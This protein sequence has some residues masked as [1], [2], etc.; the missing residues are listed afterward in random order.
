MSKHYLRVKPRDWTGEEA[1]EPPSLIYSLCCFP[2]GSLL[3]CK[4]KQETMFDRFGPGIPLYF[5][6]LQTMIF[7]SVIA[8]CFSIY[9]MSINRKCNKPI[10]LFVIP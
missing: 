6:Y 5:I 4:K 7:F 1:L 10:S 2:I 9:M 3:F 8:A